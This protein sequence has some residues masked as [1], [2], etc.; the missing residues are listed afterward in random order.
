MYNL[1]S[2]IVHLEL[3]TNETCKLLKNITKKCV[4]AGPV[5]PYKLAWLTAEASSEISPPRKQSYLLY[6]GISITVSLLR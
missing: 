6:G 5:M 2:Y 1:F 4:S 3:S